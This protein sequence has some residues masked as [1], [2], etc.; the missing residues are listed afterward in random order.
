M[1]VPSCPPARHVCLRR[2]LR[3]AMR[4]DVCFSAQ[5]RGSMTDPRSRSRSPRSS[6][7]ADRAPIGGPAADGGA[8]EAVAAVRAR[9]VAAANLDEATSVRAAF[10]DRRANGG[11]QL[12]AQA[13]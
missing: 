9:P 6:V 4:A 12:P 11:A 3:R 2:S 8:L 7:L 13:I 5:M 10:A 1:Y